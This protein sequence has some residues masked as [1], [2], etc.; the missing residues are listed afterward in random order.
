M[1]QGSSQKKGAF[2]SETNG[3]SYFRS[4]CSSPKP[5][6]DI[7]CL[8][9]IISSADLGTTIT[10]RKLELRMWT[11]S[12]KLGRVD[13]LFWSPTGLLKTEGKKEG[14]REKRNN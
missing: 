12:E 8:G 7:E 3:S 13:S 9:S 14:E 2:P 4:F 5:T 1:K 6:T 11:A 10:N